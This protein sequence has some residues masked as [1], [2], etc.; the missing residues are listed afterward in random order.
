VSNQE[1]LLTVILAAITLNLVLAIGI[2]LGSRVGRGDPDGDGDR[3]R[4]RFGRQAPP[5]PPARPMVPLFTA[6]PHGHHQSDPQTGL[7]IG[8]TWDRWLMEEDARTKRYRRPA[9][10]VVVEIDGLERLVERLGPAAGDRLI[11]PVAATMRKFARQSDRVAR[12]GP[13]RFGTILVETDEVT[14]I[15]YVERI[16][17]ACDLW[18]AAGAVALRLSIGWAEANGSRSM[19]DAANAAEERLNGERRRNAP[20]GDDLVGDGPIAEPAPG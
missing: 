8:A 13:A 12:L 10:V 18:L 20:L 1:I 15:N 16:R 9:T 4:G 5:V 19:E 2:L 6:P 11:P 17:S 14:A 3:P 7:E